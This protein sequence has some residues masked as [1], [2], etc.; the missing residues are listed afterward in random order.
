MWQSILNEVSQRDEVGESHLVVLG[1]KGA[2]KRSLLKALNR[3]CVHAKNN[4]IEVDKMMSHYA[5]I[6]F[7]FLYAKDLSEADALSA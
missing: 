7:G 1:D 4:L 6:D 3:H 2:G 5:G